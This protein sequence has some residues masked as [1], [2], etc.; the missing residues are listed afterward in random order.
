M[1]ALVLAG[2]FAKRMGALGEY[3]PKA[4]FPVGDISLMEHITG[5]LEKLG[6]EPVITTN[7]KFARFF[8]HYR[9]VIVE[10]ATQEK[11]KLGAVSAINNAVKSIGTDD[12]LL[13]ICADNYFS[14]DLNDFVYAY[15]GTVTVGIY[16]AGGNADMKPEEMATAKFDGCDRHPLFLPHWKFRI[17]EFKEK[18][19]PPLSRYVST[20][21]YILPRRVLPMLDEFCGGAKRDAPGFFI[22][23]LFDRGEPVTGHLFGGEWFDLSHKAYIRTF[24]N[25]ELETRNDSHIVLVKDLEDARTRLV[26]VHPNAHTVLDVQ[27]VCIFIGGTGEINV[28][29]GKV[30]PVRSG[31]VVTDL[32]CWYLVRNTSRYSE[33]LFMIVSEKRGDTYEQ[34]R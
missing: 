3:A 2:G 29:E 24:S 11:E 19:N 15:D 14:S 17:I 27:G 20:G 25:A 23:H 31:N 28:E 9:N 10:D 18:V 7:R 8:S 5:K 33:L 6:I 32:P 30:I 21:I 16:Y 22:Q 13:V 12:D 1:R 34:V 4:A 26:A